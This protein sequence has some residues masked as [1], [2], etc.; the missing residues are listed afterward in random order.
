MPSSLRSLQLS[1]EDY[2]SE[3]AW[4]GLKTIIVQKQVKLTIRHYN[5]YCDCEDDETC[6]G[7]TFPDLLEQFVAEGNQTW[8]KEEK[9]LLEYHFS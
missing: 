3:E 4:I 5:F 9:A 1:I 2:I 7:C 8:S 6:E